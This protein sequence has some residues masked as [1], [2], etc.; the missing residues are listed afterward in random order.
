[1]VKVLK[2]ET[3]EETLKKWAHCLRVGYSIWMPCAVCD[4]VGFSNCERRCPMAVS[5]WCL[6]D[7][8]DSKLYKGWREDCREYENPEEEKRDTQ[9]EWESRV[10]DFLMWIDLEIEA[11]NLTELNLEW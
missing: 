10:C 9:D 2:T 3:L 4:E 11:R 6:N 8:V 1:M 5:G 7:A